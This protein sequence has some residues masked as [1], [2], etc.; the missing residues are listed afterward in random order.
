[1]D[2]VSNELPQL[3]KAFRAEAIFK[4]R[5]GS[6]YALLPFRFLRLDND[7][8]IS[9]NF[10]GEYL[11]LSNED[12]TSL[13]RHS[14]K[15]EAAIYDELKSKHFL[16]DSDSN[17][18]LDLL[19]CK[20]RTKHSMLS[21]LTS[22]F[23][24]VVTLRCEHSCP[25]CQVS[26]QSQNREA[27]DMQRDDAERA[28]DFVFASPAHVIKIEFQGGEPLLNFDLIRWIVNR[29]HE[30][31]VAK[32]ISF[33]ITTNLALVSSEVLD[34]CREHDIL[35]STSLDGP[36]E[37]H[38]AN[39]PR[40]GN[41]SF[42]RTVKAIATVRET[43]GSDRIAALMTTTRLSLSQPEAIIDEYVRHGFSS[44]FLRS[45]SPFGFAVK[46]GAIGS[47]TVDEWL[48]FYKRSLA[49]ILRLNQEGTPFREEYA[50]LLLRKILTPF[51]TGYVDLQSPAGM[52][53]SCIAFN[54]DGSIYASD[55]ARMLAEMKDD[56]FCL[57][58]LAT[59]SFETV[60]SSDRLI[61]LLSQTLTESVP[62]CA[63]CGIQPYCGSDPV[64]H[65]ATQGDP[66]GMKPL[67][68]FCH[69]NMEIVK[70]LIRLLEDD[71][72]AGGILRSWAV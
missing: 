13:V 22:L 69:K 63:D 68:G 45:L 29:V 46:T 43:L 64:Y 48:T 36:R 2:M 54:Y 14:L 15:P 30:R 53:I 24:F 3:G 27:Y 65:Y 44:I 33:V 26:R 31:N 32:D 34:F 70:L 39:R 51:P 4:R 28:I 72:S 12:L 9:T 8:Y 60:I 40:P 10:V 7:R 58:H 50:A 17:V 37:L 56:T 38:N 41:D 49:Y 16:I 59:D 25:Y 20:Y 71:D 19:A 21:Q 5:V 61:E 35:I 42:E 47:Y 18:A 62:M 1:M 23:L 57:G 66:V 67:S 6:A 11:I 52:G 55:E